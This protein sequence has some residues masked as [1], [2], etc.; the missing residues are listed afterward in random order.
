MA[1]VAKFRVQSRTE[2]AGY[3]EPGK[4]QES[5]KLMAVSDPANENWSK[6]TPS[7]S[8]DMVITNPAALD[9]FRVGECVK[10]RFEPLG[11]ESDA[12]PE[13]ESEAPAGAGG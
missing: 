3:S 10:V 6:W 12:P 4:T 7:G 11:P 5:V 2:S 8:I 1:V 13:V 9:Q